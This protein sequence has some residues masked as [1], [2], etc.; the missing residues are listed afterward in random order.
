MHPFRIALAIALASAL[1]GQPA[2]AGSHGYGYGYKKK[3][4]CVIEKVKVVVGYDYYGKPIH[5]F[6]QVKVCH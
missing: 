5:R 6:K 3:V 4:V 2:L 1:L